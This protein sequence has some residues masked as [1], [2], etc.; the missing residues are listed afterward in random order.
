[1]K[2]KWGII[3]TQNKPDQINLVVRQTEVIKLE[4]LPTLEEDLII[5]EAIKAVIT[6][7]LNAEANPA[8]SET[9]I[10]A[11]EAVTKQQA[12]KLHLDESKLE[13]HLEDIIL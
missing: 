6:E 12:P 3:P 11:R 9:F 4:P 1:M 13:K 5:N 7:N 10:E 2:Q 8:N